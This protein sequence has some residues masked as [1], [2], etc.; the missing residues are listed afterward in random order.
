MTDVTASGPVVHLHSGDMAG[1]F[2]ALCGAAMNVAVTAPWLADT[3][4]VTCEPCRAEA[5][6][7]GLL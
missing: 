1:T 4:G 7:L 2:A 3:F 6:R 5:Q